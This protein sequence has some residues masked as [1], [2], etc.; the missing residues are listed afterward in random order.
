M[1]HDEFPH[2]VTF[3]ALTSIPDGGGGSEKEWKP[4]TTIEGFMDTPTSRERYEA[5]QLNNQLDRYLYY[6][7]GTEVK[8]NMRVTF[9]GETYEIAGRPEDQGGQHEIMRLPLKLVPNG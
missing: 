8:P 1:L 5:M 2:E 3:T 6:P 9:E 4:F 7:Y